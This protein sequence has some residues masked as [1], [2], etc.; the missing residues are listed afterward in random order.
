MR[1]GC[2]L[3]LMAFLFVAS[4]GFA[5]GTFYEKSLHFTGAGMKNGY[6]QGLRPLTGIPYEKIPECI[7]CHAN[8]CDKCHAF[9]EGETWNYSVDRARAM[10]TCLGCHGKEALVFMLGEKMGKGDVHIQKGMV[11]VDCHDAVDIHGDGK[12]YTSM[13]TPGALRASC[14]NCHDFDPSVEAHAIHKEKVTC[15]ACHVGFNLSCVNCHFDS[16]LETGRRQGN[17]FLNST[18]MLLVNHKGRVDLGTAM[19]FVAKG[20]K[21]VVY[22]PQFTHAIQAKGR[23]CGECHG[24]EAVRRIKAGGTVTMMEY[25]D[26]QNIPWKGVV[27]LVHGNLQWFFFEKEGQNW[28]PLKSGEPPKVQWW[29]C[30]PLR[31]DQLEKLSRPTP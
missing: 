21:L 12:T 28:I 26:G 17:F 23:D 31:E 25:R 3:F 13:R 2:S 14:E 6:E 27:P 22:S 4:T 5:Q 1:Q 16:F 20:K 29:Y 18:Y 19:T 24:N 7:N 9:Q 10:E 11:C 8:S 15:E 30:E